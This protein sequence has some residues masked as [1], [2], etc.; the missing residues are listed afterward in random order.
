MIAR[1]PVPATVTFVEMF[2]PFEPL[3]IP[4]PLPVM[5]RLP[6]FVVET[7][8]PVKA[9]PAAAPPGPAVPVRVN[10]PPPDVVNVP[11]EIKIP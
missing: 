6:L 3:A 8:P 11:P 10:A 9:T 7:V 2:T 1:V 5:E 4:A